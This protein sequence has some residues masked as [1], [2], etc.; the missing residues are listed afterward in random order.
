MKQIWHPWTEWE[1]YISGM[2]DGPCA[3]SLEEGKAEYASFLRDTDRFMTSIHKVM[4]DWPKSCEHFLSNK[5]MNRVAWLGQ[6]AMCMATGI[7]RG[8]RAGFMLLTDEE[9]KIAN[10]T[11]ESEIQRWLQARSESTLQ[12]G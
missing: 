1:C 6:A 9:R 11:A 3:L 4:E 8:Y 5:Q 2:Y 12:T 10:K 7:N